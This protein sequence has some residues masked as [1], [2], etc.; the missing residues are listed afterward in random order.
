MAALLDRVD[1]TDPN[2]GGS[3][4][5]LDNA[6]A[7]DRALAMLSGTGGEV[8]VPGGPDRVYDVGGPIPWRSG[9][10]FVGEAT[11]RRAPGYLGDLFTAT[12]PLSRVAVEGLTIDQNA[13]DENAMALGHPFYVPNG[14]A[15]VRLQWVRIVNVS[16]TK[17][18]LVDQ[19]PRQNRDVWLL[20]SSIERILGRRPTGP[21][22]NAVSASFYD[23]SGLRIEK[24]RFD[25]CGSIQAIAATAEACPPDHPMR[26]VT[27]E[28]NA[29]D[30]VQSTNL[31]V[32]A[33]AAGTAMEDVEIL[34]NKHR[35]GG[36]WLEKGAQYIGGVGDGEMR[37]ATVRDNKISNMG[38]YGSS[39]GFAD[40]NSAYYLLIG[41][42]ARVDGVTVDGNEIDGA[43]AGGTDPLGRA[44]G[45]TIRGTTRNVRLTNN[46]AQNLGLWGFGIVGGAEGQET[47]RVIARG[48]IAHRTCRDLP[49]DTTSA[50]ISI[51]PRVLRG[52]VQGNI[53]STNGTGSNDVAGIGVGDT[54][55]LGQ[56]GPINTTQLVSILDNL[57]YTDEGTTNQQWGVRVGVPGL[58][59]ADQP[60]YVRVR[61]NNTFTNSLGGLWYSKDGGRGLDVGE[62]Y[63]ADLGGEILISTSALSATF[64]IPHGPA[65]APLIG[66]LTADSRLGSAYASQMYVVQRNTNGAA[67]GQVV[68]PLGAPSVQAGGVAPTV[69]S[70]DAQAG[71]FNVTSAMAGA[72]VTVRWRPMRR[73]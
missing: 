62:N 37:R 10:R 30:G 5:A 9:V 38:W 21:E 16:P 29:F 72:T 57:S 22:E 70:V 58:A 67:S 14:S 56:S 19:G 27:Y 1:L 66:L 59:P 42:C 7:F 60:G 32:T 48:N 73:G 28:A 69:T 65:D 20:E 43:P 68:T 41:G 15:R 24:N 12:A 64:A 52:L 54:T 34:R 49:I 33:F 6:P 40:A 25:K 17:A 50:G 23:C 53:S 35:D 31:F 13:D 51:G 47:K 46:V 39:E 26:D 44:S 36:H 3:A 18:I 63:G 71:S 55:P 11:I 4:D 61:D 2:V 45:I 8:V